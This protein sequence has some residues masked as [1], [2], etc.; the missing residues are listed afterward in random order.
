MV[1]NHFA[2]LFRLSIASGIPLILERGPWSS[3][4]F[5]RSGFD[6]GNL[7]KTDFRALMSLIKGL[8]RPALVVYINTPAQV[9]L[10]RN[11]ERCRINT[12]ESKI[13]LGYL[14]H[15]EKFHQIVVKPVA[16]EVDG[17]RDRLDVLADVHKV[18]ARVW[19]QWTG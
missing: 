13:G 8:P 5:T 3:E 12:Y 6:S 1:Y 18:I 19:A 11:R 2:R 15:L 10:E 14:Q 9:C 17:A 16:V 7:N 4:V